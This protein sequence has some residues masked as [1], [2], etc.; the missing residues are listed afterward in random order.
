MVFLKPRT[1]Y[2]NNPP[3]VHLFLEE[4]T[5]SRR[6]PFSLRALLFTPPVLCIDSGR[7]RGALTL[8]TEIILKAQP[9]VSSHTHPATASL[10][11]HVLTHYFFCMKAQSFWY[12]A[13]PPLGRCRVVD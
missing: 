9:S 4:T 6:S 8:Q 3:P 2:A 12:V 10:Q 1:R 5:R 7:P 11:S 13:F